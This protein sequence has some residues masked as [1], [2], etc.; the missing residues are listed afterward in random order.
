L[1]DDLGVIDKY[2]C[3]PVYCIDW[4]EA[5]DMLNEDY[6]SVDFDGV[7]YWIRS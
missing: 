7:T 6:L 2:A 5:A 3:W 4:E 1:A